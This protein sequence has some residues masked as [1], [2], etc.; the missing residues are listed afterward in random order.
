MTAP[1]TRCGGCVSGEL[2][3]EK[4]AEA[5]FAAAKADEIG[6]CIFKDTQNVLPL[7]AGRARIDGIG[8]CFLKRMSL[9]SAGQGIEV[10]WLLEQFE[11]VAKTPGALPCLTSRGGLYWSI[12]ALPARIT[13]LSVTVAAY[14]LESSE[15]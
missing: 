8:L 14:L 4:E 7:F 15:K 12:S 5:I 2:R 13:V 3:I 1:S 6:A 9:H 11:G 10:S